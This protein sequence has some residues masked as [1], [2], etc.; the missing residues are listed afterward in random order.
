LRSIQFV[1]L[2]SLVAMTA[3]ATGVVLDES[4]DPLA[5][6]G[7]ETG[8]GGASASGGESGSGG[9]EATGGTPVQCE[10]GEK[11]CYGAC[12]PPFPGVGCGVD[13]CTR[14]AGTNPDN[15]ALACDKGACSITCDDGYQPSGGECVESTSTG[16]STGSGGTGG[17]TS[18]GGAKATGGS[19]GG[20]STGGAKATGGSTSTGGA[21]ATGGSTSTGGA[22]ATGGGG[23]ATQCV[24]RSCPDC[25]VV[26]GPACCTPQNKCGCPIFY[27]PG[28][29]G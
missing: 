23:G 11:F 6:S 19:T 24:P 17:G 15:G 2:S 10:P 16:G 29:C 14:C 9:A 18:T 4:T 1:F 27:I 12:T 8:E 13:D 28:T 3:C 5:S 7:G 26:L 20:T 22:K 25:G 21:K